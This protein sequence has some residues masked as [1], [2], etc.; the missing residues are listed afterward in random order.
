M[1]GVSMHLIHW[2]IDIAIVVDHFTQTSI[3]IL[4][5][6]SQVHLLLHIEEEGGHLAT[7]FTLFAT[8]CGHLLFSEYVQK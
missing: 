8:E 5:Y 7:L 2:C 3:N 6:Q 1:S 4:L